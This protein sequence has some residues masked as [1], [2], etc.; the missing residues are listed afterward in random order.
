MPAGSVGP[1][2]RRSGSQAPSA[3]QLNDMI[4]M[5]GQQLDKNIIREDR[6]PYAQSIDVAA[7]CD[8]RLQVRIGKSDVL[9]GNRMNRD[10]IG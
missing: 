8:S 1:T 9:Q 5:L 4:T 7:K 2:E 3:E 6:R 10:S